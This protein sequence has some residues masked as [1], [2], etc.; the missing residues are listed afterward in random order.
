MLAGRIVTRAGAVIVP[1]K[2]AFGRCLPGSVTLTVVETLSQGRVTGVAAGRV[3][4]RQRF[5]RV[6][7]GK[8]TAAPSAGRTDLVVVHLNA[9]G[10]R[11]LRHWRPLPVRVVVTS[12]I[13][14][15]AAT[16]LRIP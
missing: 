16:Q 8:A 9:T 2:C 1:L 3:S 7:V 6:V 4:R 11:L 13:E 14:L 12:G 15:L 5:L 10:R